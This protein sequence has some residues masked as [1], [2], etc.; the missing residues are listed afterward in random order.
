MFILLN[1]K[2]FLIFFFSPFTV[3]PS[4]PKT[5]ANPDKVKEA[6]NLLQYAEKP[7][8]IVGKGKIVF[9]GHK[10]PDKWTLSV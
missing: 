5:L 1:I 6:A 2:G 3:C 10:T 7:L 9:S 4:P 8:V